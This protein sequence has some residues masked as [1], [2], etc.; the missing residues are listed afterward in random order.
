MSFGV[1]ARLDYAKCVAHH[2]LY[3]YNYGAL[4]YA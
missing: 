2:I 3:V 1:P 4:K